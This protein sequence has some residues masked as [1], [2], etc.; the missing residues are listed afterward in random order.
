MFRR[1]VDLPYLLTDTKTHLSSQYWKLADFLCPEQSNYVYFT[2]NKSTII[3][4][5]EWLN[6]NYNINNPFEN[7]DLKTMNRA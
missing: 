5:C 6:N 3:E 7:A 2:S 1:I 4:L